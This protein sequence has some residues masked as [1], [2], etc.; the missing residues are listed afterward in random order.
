MRMA[1]AATIM[2]VPHALL[3]LED[4]TLAYIRKES[5]ERE[6]GES[7]WKISASFQDD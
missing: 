2:T 1:D 3:Y 6:R 5:T 4:G 7:L